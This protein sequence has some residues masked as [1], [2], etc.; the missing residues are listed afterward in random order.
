M[1]ASAWDT[2]DAIAIDGIVGKAGTFCRLVSKAMCDAHGPAIKQRPCFT[3]AEEGQQ[4][5]LDAIRWLIED[6]TMPIACLDFSLIPGLFS[7]EVLGLLEQRVQHLQVVVLPWALG[8]SF[9]DQ[10]HLVSQLTQVTSLDVSGV[11]SMY[12]D[13]PRSLMHAVCS[14][15]QL[16]ALSINDSDI[17]WSRAHPDLINGLVQ[18]QTLLV[19]S[20]PHLEQECEVEEFAYCLQHLTKLTALKMLHLSQYMYLGH[21]D[22]T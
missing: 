14:M 2:L 11:S 9:W 20:E 16:Q 6:I 5:V 17:F 1:P 12:A 19:K 21:G 8:F 10:G 13:L 4:A 18:L 3:A 7:E 22:V 15:T